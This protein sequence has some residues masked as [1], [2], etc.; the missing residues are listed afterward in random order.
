MARQKQDISSEILD[1]ADDVSIEELIK[2]VQVDET[3]IGEMIEQGVIEPNPSRTTHFSAVTI[4]TVRRARRLE[5]DF[6]LNP[7]G[8]ALALELL[9]EIERLRAQLKRT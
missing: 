4:T 6:N 7:S 1:D 8:V 2:L 9:D 3:W 5:R